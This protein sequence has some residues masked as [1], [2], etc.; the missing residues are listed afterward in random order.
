MESISFIFLCKWIFPPK[1]TK[2]M[3]VTLEI[4]STCE[5]DSISSNSNLWINSF[6]RW[7]PP[8]ANPEHHFWGNRILKY[9]KLCTV[10]PLWPKIFHN[11]S[12][13]G[14]EFEHLQNWCFLLIKPEIQQNCYFLT[15]FHSGG[16]RCPPRSV[17]E[18]HP[19]LI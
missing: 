8:V 14:W 13:V 7:I 16:R 1:F 6:E 18:L 9:L 2:L 17:A 4:E 19:L 12:F 3:F 15:F 11:F 10:S 5:F